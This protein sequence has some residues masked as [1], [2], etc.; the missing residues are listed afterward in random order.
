MAATTYRP[1]ATPPVH[2]FIQPIMKGVAKPARLPTELMKA[3]P[4]A[5][6]VPVK[7]RRNRPEHGKRAQHADSGYAQRGHR[8]HRVADAGGGQRE[9]RRADQRG[10]GAMQAPLAGLVGVR[11]IEHHRHGAQR[12]GDRRQQA[13]I[14]RAAH[15]Q[16][17]HQRRHPERQRGVA[18]DDAEVGG[19]AQPQRRLAQG[20]GE[21]GVLAAVAL[22]GLQLGFQRRR[23]AADSQRAWRGRS[24]R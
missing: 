14:Q 7:A 3:M 15:A 18:A 10:A 6:A 9:P 20:L 1:A 24:G 17:A 21:A 5:A 23:S 2:S 13:D 16:L 11:A 19:R 22:L 4:P 12:E 8:Q